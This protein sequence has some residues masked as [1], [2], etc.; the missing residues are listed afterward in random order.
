[1]CGPTQGEQ[2]LRAEQLIMSG[3]SAKAPSSIE[4]AP[5]DIVLEPPTL[6][7]RYACAS[8][9]VGIFGVWGNICYFP[10]TEPA[11]VGD[12][13]HSWEVPAVLTVSYLLLLPLLRIL[14][15]TFLSESIDVKL[16]LKE[17]MVVY[18]GGQVILNSWMVYKI[19]EGLISKDHPFIGQVYTLTPGVSHALWIHYVDK[20]LEFFD[21]FFMVLRGRMDQVSELKCY[22][23]SLG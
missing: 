17:T 20:Y 14:S 22:H 8:V 7:A 16:L 3:K 2:Q 19:L 23:Y 6:L 11:P 10:D 1:M 15:K 13:L 9:M 12:L 21:T 4:K 5:I 18:N